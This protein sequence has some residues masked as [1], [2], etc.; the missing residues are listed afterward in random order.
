MYYG[1]FIR[2]KYLHQTSDNVRQR[3][4][5][6]R[7]KTASQLTQLSRVNLSYRPLRTEK[8]FASIILSCSAFTG[9]SARLTHINLMFDF[10]PPENFRKL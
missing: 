6:R 2:P 10:L 9:V 4:K 1:M 5:L 3:I 8:H 7:K